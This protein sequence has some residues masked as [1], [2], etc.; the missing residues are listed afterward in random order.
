MRSYVV[1][2]DEIRLLQQIRGLPAHERSIAFAFVAELATAPNPDIRAPL[3]P[4]VRMFERIV[5]G[6]CK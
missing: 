2:E 5:A 6:Q 4:N 3:P 1:H